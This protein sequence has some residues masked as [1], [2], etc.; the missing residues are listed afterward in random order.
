MPD[1]QTLPS[2][3]EQHEI[4][5]GVAV[6]ENYAQAVLDI[7]A[8][9]LQDDLEANYPVRRAGDAIVWGG[10]QWVE[11]DNRALRYRGKVL[12]RG[13]MWFQSGRPQQVGFVKYYYTGWQRRVLPA[14]A[15]VADCPELSPAVERYNLWS[16]ALGFPS[17]NHFI[18]THYVDGEHN[19]GM[20]FDKPTSIAADSLIT[21]VKTG[22]HGRPFRLEKLDGTLIFERVLAPGTAVVMTLAANLATKHG[23][24]AVE[25]AGSSGSVV[26]RTIT[27][28]VPWER[29]QHELEKLDAQEEATSAGKRKAVR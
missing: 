18:V 1:A 22:A 13:K 25:Q 17:A 15:D 14:T 10:A 8:A 12:K 23:V 5:P 20:H 11:G 24:P 7:D 21:V 19:I 16:T 6:I 29:L 9:A 3:L 26:F 4:W 2:Q 28:V 27:D